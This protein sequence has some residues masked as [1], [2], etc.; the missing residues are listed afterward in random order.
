MYTAEFN[1]IWQTFNKKGGVK[2]K[3]VIQTLSILSS[4]A[5]VVLGVLALLVPTSVIL[6]KSMIITGFIAAVL[7][8]VSI[9]WWRRDEEDYEKN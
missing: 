2:M 9:E 1:Y 4:I 3:S 6:I 5:L 7:I 8:I